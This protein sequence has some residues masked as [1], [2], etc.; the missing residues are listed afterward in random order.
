MHLERLTTILE[1]VGQKGQA[2]VSDICAHSDLPKPSVYRL[3]QDLVSVGLL[4]TLAR[5]QF[6]I[7]TRLKRITH[8]DHTDSVLV[9]VISPVL[10]RAANEHGAAF[11]LSRLRGRSVEIFHVETPES[12]VSYLHPGMG[13]RPLHACSCSKAIAAFSPDVLSWSE[14]SGRLK[15]Y[16][17][18]TITSLEDLAAELEIVRQRGYA[19]C[20]EELERGIC[21]VASPLSQSGPGTTLSIGATGSSRVFSPEKRKRTGRALIAMSSNI[22]HVLGWTNEET[23]RRSA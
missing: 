18:R 4:D 3:V 9:E 16:T 7:G 5:G 11:F 10:A 14:L 23:A 22:S 21:S 20:V 12:N 17:D 6:S 13:K 2:S 19:E 15:T 1:I 8:R